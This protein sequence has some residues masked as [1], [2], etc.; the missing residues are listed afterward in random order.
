MSKRK[1][2]RRSNKY[3]EISLPVDYI[4]ET[5]DDGEMAIGVSTRHLVQVDFCPT[6][7][8]DGVLE[9]NAHEARK[10]GKALRPTRPVGPGGSCLVHRPDIGLVSARA[11]N[12]GR[13]NAP[14]LLPIR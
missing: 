10:L 11:L 1:S 12:W 3:T 4:A 9:L 2:V 6:D 7:T 8:G 5:G 14:N 13:Y